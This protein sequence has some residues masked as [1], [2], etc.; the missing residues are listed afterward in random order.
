ML[1]RLLSYKHLLHQPHS[2]GLELGPGFILY[3]GDQARFHPYVQAIPWAEKAG[4]RLT[5]RRADSARFGAVSVSVDSTEIHMLFG[6]RPIRAAHP[7][8]PTKLV[9]V[10][11]LDGSYLRSYEL[12]THFRHMAKSGESY[13]L[14]NESELGLPQIRRFSPIVQRGSQR[15]RE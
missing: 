1:L 8:E 7:A 14:Y 2:N 12:P 6:G 4:P 3:D 11:G 5:A 10:Y 9:D 13:V 15:D